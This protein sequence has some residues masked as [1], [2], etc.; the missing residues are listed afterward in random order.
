MQAIIMAGGEGSRLRPL[1][2]DRPKPMV[3]LVNKPVMEYAV[4]LLKEYG[5]TDIGV[6]LQYLPEEI[7][8]YFGD[9]AGHGV[10]MRYFIEE[11]PLGTAG[12][13]KNTGG[14]LKETFIVI[15]GDALTDFNLSEII[16]FHREKKALATLVLKSVNI[17]LEYGVVITGEDGGIRR[18]L[19]KPGWGEVFSDTVNT[20]IYI[21]EPEVLEYIPAGQKFDF[22]KDLFPRLLADGRPLFG[23]A[24][25]GYWCDIGNHRQYQEAHYDMLSNRVRLTGAG[26]GPQGV[27]L[28][29]NAYVDPAAVVEPPV[30][31]G[32]NSRIEAGARIG[33]YTVIGR[34]CHIEAGASL[35][36]AILW[37]GVH[38]GRKAE[39]RGAVL[40]NRVQ[41]KDGAAVFEGAVIGDDTVLE[42]GSRI[43]PDTKIWPHKRVDKGAVVDKHLVWGTRGQKNLFGRHGIAGRV[44][45][46]LLPECAAKAGAVFGSVIGAGNR[47]VLSSDHYKAC[48][49]IKMALQSGL[50]AAGVELADLGYIVTPVHRFALRAAEAKGGVHVKLSPHD[51]EQVIIHFFDENGATISREMERKIE[52]LYYRDDFRRAARRDVGRTTFLP[53]MPDTYL[54]YL[55]SKVDRDAVRNSRLRIVAAYDAYNLVGVIPPLLDGLGCEVIPLSGNFEVAREPEPFDTLA[56]QAAAMGRFVAEQHALL[57]VM[58]DNNA[59]NMILVDETGRVIKDDLLLG[60]MALLILR[61]SQGKTVAAPVTAPGILET[62]AQQYGGRVIRTRTSPQSFLQDAMDADVMGGQGNLSQFMLAFDAPATLAGVLDYLVRERAPLSAL[63]SSIPEFHQAHKTVECPWDEKGR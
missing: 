54:A 37:E 40:C 6:T 30:V 58:L 25:G 36:R 63:I 13:V 17:P 32:R 43:K 34:D 31:I 46:D 23:Y 22:S 10:S 12:S 35:K 4:K 57:G 28:E 15:S 7:S 47:V 50:L 16:G 56:G 49:M 44:N 62:M 53:N 42:E 51:P 18:F 8:N 59:E 61:H 5:I 41:V 9:G 48:K 33:P 52:N 21:L 60:L 38:V 26:L 3:P 24:A 1:T 14:F 2:C 27:R 39:I 55:L 20:G 11:S 29:E 19:E 45:V